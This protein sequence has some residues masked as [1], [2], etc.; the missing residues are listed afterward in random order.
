MNID[1][2]LEKGYLKTIEV[3]V[4]LVQKELN[5]A[6]YD[7]DSANKAYNSG[8]T[9]WCIIKC[10]YSMFHAAKAVLFRLG[11]QEKKHIA[12]LAVLE[13][14]NKKGKIKSKLITNFRASMSAR[15]DADYNYIYS[16]EIAS[17]DL[18]ITEEFIKAMEEFINSS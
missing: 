5:E 2:C 14:L 18:N 16:N 13:E 7:F 3:D 9:K 10:Y 4:R 15:E 8:D 11:Y 12:I 1:D 6:N 17:Y